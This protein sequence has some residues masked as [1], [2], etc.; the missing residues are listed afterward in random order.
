MI[1]DNREPI[2]RYTLRQKINDIKDTFK[3]TLSL[4]K[5]NRSIGW[6]CTYTPEELITAAG[7]RPVRIFGNKKYNNAASYF[8]VN[9]CP[10]LKA[11]LSSILSESINFDAIIFTTSCDGMRR[12]YDTVNIYLPKIPSYILDVPRIN[13]KSSID[14]FSN[15][16]GD[17]IEFIENLEGKKINNNNLRDAIEL[18]N[19]K[20][21]LLRKFSKI[22]SKSSNLIDISTYYRVMKLSMTSE[23]DIFIEDLDRYIKLIENT[24]KIYLKNNSEL[25]A[26]YKNKPNVMI[27]GNFINEE[28]LWDMLSSLG[29]KLT[30][31]DLCTSSRYFEKQIKLDTNSGLLNSIAYRYINKPQCM[32]MSDLGSKLKEIENKIK[33]NNIKGVIY[34]S[35]KFCDTML[36][37][38][39]LLKQRL[40]EFN[41]PTLYLE[42]EY[43]N[44][45]EGQVKT[46]TQAF[47]E[48][49]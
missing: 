25:H 24:K 22:F 41:I 4:K 32:R 21:K 34:I 37:G 19:Y 46:R 38:F 30:T 31:D 14:F 6:L 15:N 23:P 2:N 13:N 26:N 28:K 9:F 7:Y 12:L 29:C 44:F 10:Y 48:M 47:L 5:N 42:I 33:T 39:P 1:Q 18:V 27:I 8:P 45:S 43:N 17:F 35:L 36:Y 3:K 16:L 20:R 11:S 40:D 49:L